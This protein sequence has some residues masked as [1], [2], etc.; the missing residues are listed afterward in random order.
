MFPVSKGPT[1]RLRRSKPLPKQ[2]VLKHTIQDSNTITDP[3]EDQEERY[4]GAI[5]GGCANKEHLTM[6]LPLK[7]SRGEEMEFDVL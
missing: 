2:Q 1:R 7:G 6:A 5:E 3:E 4:E